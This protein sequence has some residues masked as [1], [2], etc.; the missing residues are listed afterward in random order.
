MRSIDRSQGT[1]TLEGHDGRVATLAVD[2][3]LPGFDTLS[4]G[5][6]VHARFTEAVCVAVESAVPADQASA[7]TF[8]FVRSAQS[9]SYD[10]DSKTVALDVSL[11]GFLK[12]WGEGADSFRQD[13]P[14][15]SLSVLGS[16]SV[17]PAVIELANPRLEN[18]R[19]TYQV[20]KVLEGEL[21]AS[22]GPCSLFID[23]L[24]KSGGKGALFGGLIGAIAGD[25][26]KGAA[27]GAGVGAVGGLVHKKHEKKEKEQEQAVAEANT[28]VV[29]VPNSNGSYTPVSLHLVANGWQGPKGET[30]PTLPT[31]SQLQGAYGVK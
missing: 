16:D 12:L 19:L 13:P 9:V 20:A 22:G 5:D 30:Y 15:A 27:I 8:L 10:A 21:P 25:P 26:K 4:V 2:S 17:Q 18:G 31:A 6:L 23:G 28:R 11:P 14:N 29:N 3:S 24:F 1:L 7:M